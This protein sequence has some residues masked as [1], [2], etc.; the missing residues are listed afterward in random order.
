MKPKYLLII[1]VLLIV[2][3][4]IGAVAIYLWEPVKTKL[5]FLGDQA[6]NLT[7]VTEDELN[8]AATY[9][10]STGT[11][12]DQGV[13]LVHSLESDRSEWVDLAQD[14]QN[15][16]FEVITLDLRGHGLSDGKL[17]KF[18]KGDFN[19]M[20]YDVREAFEYL[21]DINS[22]IKISVIGSS[23]GANVGL[24]TAAQDNRV[25]SLVLLSPA[26]EYKEVKVDKKIQQ[27]INP[28][29]IVSSK[30]D[31]E[32]YQDSGQ[33]FENSESEQ[34]E[35]WEL[36]KAGHGSKMLEREEGLQE[37]I[38]EWLTIPVL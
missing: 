27:Y 3:L 38:I 31:K 26:I 18:Q 35:F 23:L 34:K 36:E 22:E 15:S 5:P 29:L 7:F 6:Y 32:S 10:P 2:A 16:G 14:L 21:E 1:I 25:Q 17:K 37:R 30:N 28:L 24:K 19:K 9:Y 20:E 8:I 33:L 13:V 11:I 4:V 12:S